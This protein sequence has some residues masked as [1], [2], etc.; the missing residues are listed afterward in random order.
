M[1]IYLHELSP[2]DYWFPFPEDAMDDPNGLLAFGGDLHPE[3]ILAAYQQGIFPWFGPGEPIL[4]WSPAPRAVFDPVR[5]RPSRSVRKFQRKARYSVTLNQ[6]TRSV[7]AKCA[8]TRTAEETWLNEDMIS[9]YTQLS[10]QGFCHSVEVWKDSE[11]VGGLYG[12]CIGQIFC[13]ESMFSTQDNASKIALWYFCHHFALH[14][15]KLIDCQVMN[16]HLLSLG[17]FELDRDNYLSKLEQS[18]VQPLSEGCF[19][20]QTLREP[21]INRDA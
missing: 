19:T 10:E 3:R 4:W 9:A 17:A 21:N 20:A 18:R 11:L 5:F 8:S 13:G 2:S 7:I 1:T 16:D 14:G 15:G 6:A 12:L